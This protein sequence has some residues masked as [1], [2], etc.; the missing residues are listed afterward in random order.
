MTTPTPPRLSGDPKT[1]LPAL[2]KYMGDIYRSLVLED[3]LPQT[4]AR[5]GAVDITGISDAGPDSKVISRT[6]KHLAIFTDPPTAD[7]METL[8]QL[9]NALAIVGTK[10]IQ[11]AQLQ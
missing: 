1:D 7:E 5:L 8:R 6:G 3:Q 2:A 9:V 11:A 10:I 4:R